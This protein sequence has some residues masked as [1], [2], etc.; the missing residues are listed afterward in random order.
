[1]LPSLSNPGGVLI[2]VGY[3]PPVASLRTRPARRDEMMATNHD[4]AARR[5]RER[6]GARARNVVKGRD[7]APDTETDP[8]RHLMQFHHVVC[9][10]DQHGSVVRI[11]LPPTPVRPRS[12]NR[13]DA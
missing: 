2:V 12:A 13:A 7:R 1:M 3:V 8:A 10:E 4:V 9:E 5:E 6:C 11:S